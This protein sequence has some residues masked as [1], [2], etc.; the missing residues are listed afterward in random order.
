MW[1]PVGLLVL[2]IV[3]FA[4][5][6]PLR[7]W[8]GMDDRDLTML[9]LAAQAWLHGLDPYDGAVLRD[10]AA[11]N[12]MGIGAAWSLHPPTTYVLLWPVAILPWPVVEKVSVIANVLLELGCLA[13]AMSVAGLRLREPR[14]VLFVAFGLALAPFH[15]AISEGQLT[16]AVATLVMAALVAEVHDRPVASGVCVALAAAL[17]PQLGLI[18]VLL[19]LVRGR[20]RA[21]GSALLTIGIVAGLG[22][23]RAAAAGVD[24]LPTLLSNLAASGAGEAG[25]ATTQRLNLQ[26]LLNVLVPNGS[27]VVLHGLTYAV[28]IVAAAILFVSLRRRRDREA[29][30]LVYA[31]CA[32]ITL[33]SVYN[34]SYG[35]TLLVLPLA[36]AFTPFRTPG[37]RSAAAL[38]CLAT[39]VFL[40]PGAAALAHVGPPAG[41]RW[42]AHAWQFLQLH[43]VFALLAVLGAVL[44]AAARGAPQPAWTSALPGEGALLS[45]AGRA[46]R[47]TSGALYLQSAPAG[48]NSLPRS[49][50]SQADG[51]RD[52][53]DRVPRSGDS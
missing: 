28:A 29:I 33:L 15:T 11:A 7:A 8:A 51:V 37:L 21:L 4:V 47:G 49:V 53:E 40:V 31:G 14:G 42:L 32:V 10:L 3:Y 36:W 30:L 5:R 41:M 1:V 43:Q 19:L 9:Y 20:W 6:G 52:V 35:A 2:S 26:A 44:V 48:P 50:L 18:F 46:R 34:R 38:V 45:S 39:A 12:H 17:K 24:W 16:I 25:E 27:E 23:A 13:M 22:L